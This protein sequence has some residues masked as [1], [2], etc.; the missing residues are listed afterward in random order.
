MNSYRRINLVFICAKVYNKPLLNEIQPFKDP[1]L[2]RNHAKLVRSVKEDK[3]CKMDESRESDDMSS[4]VTIPCE[5]CGLQIQF[6][7]FD[8]AKVRAKHHL[9]A[10]ALREYYGAS[11]GVSGERQEFL[12]LLQ[13]KDESIASKR[14]QASQCE[15]EN[16]ADGFM[17]DL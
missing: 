17:R 1:I 16:L 2:R 6:G 5:Q 4:G 9:V 12:R 3:G 7:A 8:S 10:N 14:N 15:Y 11:I 13:N